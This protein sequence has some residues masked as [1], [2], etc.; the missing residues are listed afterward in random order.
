MEIPNRNNLAIY[1]QKIFDTL[2]SSERFISAIKYLNSLD[3]NKKSRKNHFEIFLLINSIEH[4]NCYS[5]ENISDIFNIFFDSIHDFGMKNIH[6][7]FEENSILVTS[8]NDD[9]DIE[10]S[11][12][13]SLKT[14]YIRKNNNF[15]KE[16]FD[17]LKSLF[18]CRKMDNLFLELFEYFL[19][20]KLIADEQ[21]L[22]N[23]VERTRYLYA[24]FG[25]VDIGKISY[26]TE[27]D[28]IHGFYSYI[29][30]GSCYGSSSSFCLPSLDIFISQNETD[31]QVE[32]YD[33]LKNLTKYKQFYTSLIIELR[34]YQ[35]FTKN[36]GKLPEIL[37]RLKDLSQKQN[38]SLAL[39]VE[40]FEK[41]DY[42]RSE[43]P[44]FYGS[45]ENFTF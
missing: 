1:D 10:I 13:Y 39:F 33:I 36:I 5:T 12:K 15:L 6:L 30:Y 25:I 20:L 8:S 11:K 2:P 31:L 4:D 42:F 44:T 7:S 27:K 3:M 14:R 16:I 32:D 26:D 23:I 18:S 29:S 9:N 34:R 24:F 43:Y 37:E 17:T 45:Y 41:Q 19:S 22:R 35:F 21:K 38:L 28:E 40:Y